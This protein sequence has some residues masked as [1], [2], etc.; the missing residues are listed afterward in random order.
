MITVKLMG[1]LGNQMFQYALGR[2]LSIKNKTDLV[3]DL[4]FLRHRLPSRGYVFR[5]LDLDVFNFPIRTTVASKV[6]FPLRTLTYIVH[7]IFEQIANI[8]T[9]GYII[10]EKQIYHFDPSVL[11]S[12]AL[13]YLSGFWN[14]DKYFK[15]IED[16]IRTDFSSYKDPLDEA[17]QH[18]LQQIQQKTS[19]SVYFRRTDYV[20]NV[21]NKKFLGEQTMDYYNN[22][23][24]HMA[25]KVT[26]PHFFIFS[27]DIEWCKKNVVLPYLTTFVGQECAGTKFTGFI[28][29]MS[30][31]KHHVITNSTFSWWPAWLNPSKEKIVIAPKH[32]V[33]DTALDT[34]DVTP[35]EWIRM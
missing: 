9:P 1:G 7:R 20:T 13:S 32:W 19:V 28:R 25:S 27:D 14:S 23:V 18:M 21:L 35:S 6:P 29:L 5:D 4:S 10:K 11:D 12:P 2:H 15:E 3:L 24:E 30:A 33:A 8:A 34:T 16:T 17:S 31:C 22:A 26:D